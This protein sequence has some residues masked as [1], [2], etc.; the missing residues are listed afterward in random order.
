MGKYGRINEGAKKSNLLSQGKI[1]A[2]ELE[3]FLVYFLGVFLLM[4]WHS[5]ISVQNIIFIECLLRLGQLL[6][7]WAKGGHS[8]WYVN[9]IEFC[10]KVK[11]LWE[12]IDSCYETD[13]W[14]FHSNYLSHELKSVLHCKFVHFFGHKEHIYD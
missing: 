5:H 4:W 6:N 7:F 8:I 11:P 3:F 10:E 13:D 1:T 9:I 2:W 14:Q 12:V